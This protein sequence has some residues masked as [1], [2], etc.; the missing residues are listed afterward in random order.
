[1]R[2]KRSQRKR[3]RLGCTGK[4]AYATEQEAVSRGRQ[5]AASSM[6]H[7]RAYRCVFCGKWHLGATRR[8]NDGF[9]ESLATDR[10]GSTLS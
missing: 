10:T 5:E 1:M 3:R 6:F 8:L 2:H 4:T 9:F 7:T